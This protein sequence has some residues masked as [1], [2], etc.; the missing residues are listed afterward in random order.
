MKTWQGYEQRGLTEDAGVG[1]TERR[2][3]WKC[4]IEGSEQKYI[5]ERRPNSKL[6][7]VVV[8]NGT[9]QSHNINEIY[10]VQLYQSTNFL[11]ACRELF[12]IFSF[13]HKVEKEKYIQHT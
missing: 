2:S 10:N 1:I 4:R 12:Y 9:N 5:D 13:H 7:N 3:R 6:C 8:T 11:N